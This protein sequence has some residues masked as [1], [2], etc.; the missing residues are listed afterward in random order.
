MK[1]KRYFVRYA[2]KVQTNKYGEVYSYRPNYV[3]KK[4]RAFSSRE[5]REK[6]RKDSGY[7]ICNIHVEEVTTT[8][9]IKYLWRKITRT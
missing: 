9:W 8:S 3:T 2:E 5:A 4:V 1:I 7:D 6:V